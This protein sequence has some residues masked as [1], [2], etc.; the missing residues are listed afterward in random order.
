MNVCVVFSVMESSLNWVW[1]GL[2]EHGMTQTQTQVQLE[3]TSCASTSDHNDEQ[4]CK[5]VINW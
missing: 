4:V 3:A 5:I 2:L 1:F